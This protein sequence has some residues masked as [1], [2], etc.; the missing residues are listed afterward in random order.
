[1][2]LLLF[3]SAAGGEG[4]ERGEGAEA[5]NYKHHSLGRGSSICLLMH[6]PAGDGSSTGLL[7]L[8][9]AGGRRGERRGRQKHR[10]SEASCG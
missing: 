5:Y 2:E 3:Q 8:L 10:A 1:M 4:G 7:L 9:L 6:R